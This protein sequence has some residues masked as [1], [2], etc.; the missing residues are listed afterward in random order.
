MPLLLV[1]SLCIPPLPLPPPSLF[2]PLPPSLPPSLSSSPSSPPPAPLLFLPLPLLPPSLVP[3]L[4]SPFLPLP[5]SLPPPP[6]PLPLLLSSQTH[7]NVDKQL[8]NQRS[9]LGLKQEGKSFPL[10]QDVGV[11]KW[12]LQTTDESMIPLSSEPHR[13]SSTLLEVRILITFL[14]REKKFM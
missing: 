14:L 13:R 1:C 9:T 5:P 7:P 12:R 10:N 2:L 8:F 4:L 3:P 6:P 11:L